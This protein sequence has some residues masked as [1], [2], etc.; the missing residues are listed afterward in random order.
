MHSKINFHPFE[1]AEKRV[2]TY[3]WHV[4]V[5]AAEP[6]TRFDRFTVGQQ[7]DQEANQVLVQVKVLFVEVVQIPHRYVGNDRLNLN[8]SI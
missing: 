6:E 8:L 5:Q 3:S 1:R 7:T 4:A 2:N